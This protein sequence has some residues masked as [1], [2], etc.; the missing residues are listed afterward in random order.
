MLLRQL[1]IDSSLRRSLNGGRP[2]WTVGDH[3][4]ADLWMLTLLANVS[5]PPVDDHPVRAAMEAD[6]KAAEKA[7]RAE[8]LKATFE[9]RKRMYDNKFGR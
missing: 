5:N 4:L 3:L 8:D 9:A 7:Q 6:A 1:P 2:A